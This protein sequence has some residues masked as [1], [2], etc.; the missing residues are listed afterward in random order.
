MDFTRVDSKVMR[1]GQT[2]VH[3]VSSNALFPVKMRRKQSP[4]GFKPSPTVP[5]IRLK[6]R[7]PYTLGHEHT[8]W[9]HVTNIYPHKETKKQINK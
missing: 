2:A 8:V 3:F 5:I 4:S 7:A 1:C 6:G 9:R